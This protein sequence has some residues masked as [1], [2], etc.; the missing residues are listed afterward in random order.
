MK[1]TPLKPSG[2]F[3]IV[4]LL[5]VIS[6]IA[7]LA[8]LLLPALNKARQKGLSTQCIGNMKQ[9]GM[10]VYSYSES[11]NGALPNANYTYPDWAVP[12]A[13]GN[14][15]LGVQVPERMLGKGRDSLKNARGSF[16]HCPVPTPDS[17]KDS[18]Y[19]FNQFYSYSLGFT[20]NK[21]RTPTRLMTVAE[22]VNYRSNLSYEI[23][24]ALEMIYFRHEERTNI[25]FMDGHVENRSPVRVPTKYYPPYQALGDNDFRNSFFWKDGRHPTAPGPGAFQKMGL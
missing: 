6:I 8:S 5:V 9:M 24:I 3:T 4:E 15:Q 7:I 20:I 2:N 23:S 1:I 19:G 14:W 11:S 16:V 17:D 10:V 13:S 12:G 21:V 22:A 18:S 25:T